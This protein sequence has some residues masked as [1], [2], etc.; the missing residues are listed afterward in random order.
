MIHN[1]CGKCPNG[2][3]RT[4][5]TILLVS[6]VTQVNTCQVVSPAIMR[7]NQIV[8]YVNKADILIK[9]ASGSCK[10]CSAG[11]YI[12]DHMTTQNNM[13]LRMTVVNAPM[14]IT[15]HKNIILLLVSLV[16]Q[17]NTCQ[18]VRQRSCERIK[19]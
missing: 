12:S 19:L 1:D 10:W 7:A 8:K 5:N 14:D 17:V 2:Y 18:V 15:V 13:I 16:T 9:M 6:L 4:Q 3:Y 11:K